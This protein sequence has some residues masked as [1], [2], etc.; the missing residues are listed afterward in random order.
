[1]RP[2]GDLTAELLGLATDAARAAGTVLA[3]RFRKPATGLA[4]KTSATDVVSDAD[5]E[6][7]AAVIDTIRRARPDDAF[8]GEESGVRAGSTGVTWVVDPLD[9]TINYL[10]GRPEW[11]VSIA[12]IVDGAASAAV[13]YAP[14]FSELFKATAGN[15]ASCNSARIHVAAQTDLAHALV[16]TGFA[17]QPEIRALQGRRIAALLPVVR[18]IRRGGS[19]ALDL[20]W[21]A[22][23][24]VD[25]FFEETL[26][27]W[28]VAAGTLLVQEAGGVARPLP[29]LDPERVGVLAANPV[30]ADQLGARLPRAV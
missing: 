4:T 15:G 26:G 27:P 29:P 10:Y 12:A 7:E 17:Y 16:A 1:M 18:D 14:C 21:T 25:A 2:E 24:R 30:L 9:G 28:D 23:G 20:A 19:A 13:I 11:C 8:L 5:R 3:A 22:C 6:A